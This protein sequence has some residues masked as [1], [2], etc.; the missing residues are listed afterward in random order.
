MVPVISHPTYSPN[1]SSPD[2]FAFHKLKIELKGDH[3]KNILEIQKSI[4]AKLKAIPIHEWEKAMKRLKGHA[5]E[6]IHANGDYFEIK[7]MFSMFLYY[8]ETF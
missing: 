6:S 2:Y 1:L 7:S 8:L 5:K 3:C 4:V